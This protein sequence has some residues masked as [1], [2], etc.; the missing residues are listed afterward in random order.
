[1]YRE[2]QTLCRDDGGSIVPYFINRV[3]ARRKN[4]RHDGNVAG[5]WELDG[6]RSYQRWW[7]DS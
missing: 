3:G 7:F 6:A 1:M 2:L 5:N 4:V